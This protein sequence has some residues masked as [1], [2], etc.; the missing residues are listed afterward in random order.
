M[1]VGNLVVL[2]L[3]VVASPAWATVQD[4]G[5]GTFLDVLASKT[6]KLITLAIIPVFCVLV[7]LAFAVNYNAGY[8]TIGAGLGKMIITIGVVTTAVSV[9]LGFLGTQASYGLLLL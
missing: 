2:C 8:V 4:S 5:S 7:I 6:F 1:L 9:L 3:G